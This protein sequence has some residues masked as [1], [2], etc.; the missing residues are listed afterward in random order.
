[1][2]KLT[3][4]L[5]LVII[6]GQ[7]LD[8]A[9][10]F[11]YSIYNKNAIKLN[12]VTDIY[13]SLESN[14]NLPTNRAFYYGLSGYFEL[15]QEGKI[16]N[17]QY[18]TIID[19]TLS[20][21]VKRLWVIDVH[22][23]KVIYNTYVA[24]GKNSGEDMAVKFS[25]I[26]KSNMSSLGFFLTDS[27]YTGKHGISLRLDGLEKGINDNARERAIVIHPANYV[28]KDFINKYGRLGRS[29]GCPALPVD[30]SDEI[31]EKIKGKSLIFIYYNDF[32][33]MNQSVLARKINFWFS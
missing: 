21:K 2:K 31:I 26:P 18:I 33:Y 9:N 23:K 10:I 17:R 25:N 8:R 1:M 16:E 28:S 27:I 30:I 15:L 14:D 12:Y 29:F 7:F 5:L 20:S 13:F 6:R 19:Y 11:N 24:H 4:I 22:E 32:K 3:L